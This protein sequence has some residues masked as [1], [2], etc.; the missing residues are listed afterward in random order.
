MAL[1]VGGALESESQRE[2]ELSLPFLFLGF[3]LPQA[4]PE[5]KPSAST[6]SPDQTPFIPPT[7]LPSPPPLV[8][9]ITAK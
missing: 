9:E 4:G 6:D 2:S 3:P 8:P 5:K 7:H 1:S